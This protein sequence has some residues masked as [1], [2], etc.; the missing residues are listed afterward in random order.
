TFPALATRQGARR[1]PLRP[2]R[3]NTSIRAAP[4]FP[5]TGD[6]APSS[7]V[8]QAT[9][10]K[11]GLHRSQWRE[12]TGKVRWLGATCAQYIFILDQECK[13]YAAQAERLWRRQLRGFA[14]I[15]RR[16]E[17]VRGIRPCWSSRARCGAKDATRSCRNETGGKSR[18]G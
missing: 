18:V 8:G 13:H 7:N 4:G 5:G 1:L 16:H 12:L 14:K 9:T 2:A 17:K 10:R 3:D 11:S 6:Q 15:Q